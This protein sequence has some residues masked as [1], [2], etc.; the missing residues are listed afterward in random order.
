[1]ANPEHVEILKQGVEAWN[2]WR[3]SQ[4]DLVF[5]P[6]LVGINL[7]GADLRNSNLS[8]A[9]LIGTNLC[10]VDLR[11]ADLVGTDLREADLS[12]ANLSGADLIGS[13][14]SGANLGGADLCQAT[15]IGADL[16]LA[17]FSGADLRGAD[18]SGADLRWLNL[19]RANLQG[20]NLGGADLRGA[21]LNGTNLSEANL[22]RA[23]LREANVHN[24][25]LIKTKFTNANLS[26]CKIHGISLW[27]TEIRE[28]TEQFDLI[29]SGDGAQKIVVD[30]LEVAQLIDLLINSYTLRT[31]ID[32]LAAKVVLILGHFTPERKAVLEAFR[33]EI[34]KKNYIPV[35]VDCEK[36]ALLQGTQ[37]VE[38]LARLSRLIIADATEAQG[39]FPQLEQALPGL[40]AIPV[41]L[42]LPPAGEIPES[43]IRYPWSMP[44]LRYSAIH[45]IIEPMQERIM[46]P[47]AASVHPSPQ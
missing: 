7:G 21:N 13:N 11:G 8:W 27:K 12:R 29:V 33:A 18:L 1:M 5:L 39:V 36:P 47:I 23:D 26:G 46:M 35:W 25:S 16:S 3:V 38:T 37:T 44:V 45:E 15:L 40:A 41:Q 31:V 6:N 2:Q 30:N 28:S 43:L 34:R 20:A 24:S 42:L 19:S 4:D 9:R 32:H 22:R 17:D 14:L 10:S